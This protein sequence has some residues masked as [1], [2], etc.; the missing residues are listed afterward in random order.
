MNPFVLT[1]GWY[2]AWRDHVRR[3]HENP[4][5]AGGYSRAAVVANAMYVIYLAQELYAKGKR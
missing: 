3:M 1:S 5:S 4:E 2:L